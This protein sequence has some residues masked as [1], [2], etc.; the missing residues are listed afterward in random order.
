MTDRSASSGEQCSKYYYRGRRHGGIQGIHL[1]AI[2]VSP[3]SLGTGELEDEPE[4]G[5]PSEN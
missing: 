3:D 2:R 5:N 4:D 1:K